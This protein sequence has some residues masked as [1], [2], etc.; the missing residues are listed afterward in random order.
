MIARASNGALSA[1][2]RPKSNKR[3]RTSSTTSS[4]KRRGVKIGAYAGKLIASKPVGKPKVGARVRE[5]R[6]G[7]T[8]DSS[9]RAWL[10]GSSVGCERYFCT[11]IAEALVIHILRTIKDYRTDK[12]NDQSAMMD[13]L[14]FKF[15]RDENGDG[16]GSDAVFNVDMT[17]ANDKSVDGIVRNEGST[18]NVVTFDGAEA[19]NPGLNRCIWEMATRGFYPTGVHVYRG[20]DEIYRDHTLDKATLT[21]DINGLFKFQNVTKSDSENANINAV[22]ANPLTGKIATFR[23]MSPTWNK[24]WLNQQEDAVRNSLENATGRPA[25]G[26][27]WDYS[28]ASNYS[29]PDITEL[30]AMPARMRTVFS[31]AKTSTRVYFPPGGFK[32]FKTRFT[33][34]GHLYKAIRGLTQIKTAADISSAPLHVNGKYPPLGDS[35]ALCLVPTMKSEIDETIKV[36]FD[37]QRD[38][39]ASVRRYTGGSLPTTN[40][41]Q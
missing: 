31:N 17:L 36:Q 10:T 26:D 30:E 40:M 6:F 22:D 33:F 39:F 38:G 2:S 28:Q 29:Y 32:T 21:M 23:N 5:R 9:N 13:R 18:P 27:A 3:R 8:G 12:Q 37:Y 16:S 14:V 20:T 15:G 25:T 34:K 1:R 35:F 4:R 24:G 41:F 11:L 7:D 19:T